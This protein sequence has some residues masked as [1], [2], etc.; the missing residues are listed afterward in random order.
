MAEK[1]NSVQEFYK[2]KTIFITG[3]SGFMG[4]VFIEK[5]LYSCSDLKQLI[6]L[7]RPKRG[8][9]QLER[10]KEFEKLPLFERI[11][12]EKS[13]V[14][15]KIFIVSGEITEPNL[16]MSK[17][18]LQYVIDNTNIIFHLAASLKLEATV[19]PN[20]CM[21]LIA[22]KEVLDIAKNVKKLA[23]MVHVSTAFCNVEKVTVDE[24]V[25]DTP[26][27]PMDVINTA[28]WMDDDFMA[29]FQKQLLGIHPNSYTYSKRLAEVLVRD[30]YNETK[31]PLCIVRPSV[32]GASYSEPVKGWID[33]LNGPGGVVLAGGKGV[34]RCLLIDDSAIFN[35][36]PV[37]Y[38]INSFIMIAKE[39]GTQKERASK[40]P[41]YN[42]TIH[43][44]VAKSYR[45]M[46]DACESMRYV[47]PSS[48]MLWYPNIT[49]TKNKYYYM[50][51]VILFQWIPAIFIDLLFMI[52]GQKR[53]MIHVQK[54]IAVGMDVLKCFTLNNWDFRTKNFEHLTEIQSK[55]EYEMFFVDTKKIDINQ[56]YKDSLAGGR[57]YK[58]KDPLSTIPKA[59]R[60]MKILYVLDRSVKII[61]FYFV[62]KKLLTLTGLL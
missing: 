47:F 42:V 45:H 16:G 44:S 8:K 26:E 54:K 29:S 15:K 24:V 50:F 57:V 31:L 12:K 37:D 28:K 20:I 58:D 14:M 27:K 4:K 34:L 17:E 6:L 25:Y 19:R 13:E 35:A 23:V 40:V 39:I 52:F 48:M 7:M 56:Y 60:L 18:N 55:D 30:E 22:T 61:F 51:N 49:L 41:V 38:A 1:L 59:I 33:T 62:I 32:V 11:M 9:S 53:F 36:I 2:N 43:K 21:N 10:I 46:M 3:S 5:L